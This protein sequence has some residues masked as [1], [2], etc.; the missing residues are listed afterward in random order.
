MSFSQ[1]LVFLSKQGTITFQENDLIKLNGKKYLYQKA[2][3]SKTQLQLLEPGLFGKATIILDT[4]KIETFR[5][6][7]RFRISF[8]N[9]YING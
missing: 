8:E 7:E 2:I 5:K 3:K 9:G 1:S 6:Y 4:S